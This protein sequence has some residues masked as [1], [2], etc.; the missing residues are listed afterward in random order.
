[1]LTTTDAGAPV[2]PDTPL[3]LP[4]RYPLADVAVTVAVL[5]AVYHPPPETVP[6]CAGFAAVVRKYWVVITAEYV[7][8]CAGARMVR[9]FAIEP[10]CQPLNTYCVPTWGY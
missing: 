1:M 7:A 10:S 2:A 8:D 6:P 3:Q 5:L 4:K 9:G